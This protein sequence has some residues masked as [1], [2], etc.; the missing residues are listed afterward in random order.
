MTARTLNVVLSATFVGI[1]S[2]YDANLE[3]REPIQV[4]LTLVVTILSVSGFYDFALQ[5]TL[6]SFK[7]R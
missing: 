6:K 1:L 4:A 7:I 2:V 3:S 5:P